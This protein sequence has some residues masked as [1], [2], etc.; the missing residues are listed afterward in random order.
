[1][2]YPMVLAAAVKFYHG[3]QQDDNG[4]YLTARG[5]FPDE[6]TETIDLETVV[7]REN[8]YQNSQ[9]FLL[10]LRRYYDCKGQFCVGAV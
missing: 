4:I 1:M 2:H 5:I 7:L 6:K 8:I 9:V 10:Y 3:N